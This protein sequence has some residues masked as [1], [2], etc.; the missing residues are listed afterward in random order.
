[1]D[2]DA[3][4]I[5]I[6]LLTITLIDKGNIYAEF[7]QLILQICTVIGKIF[8]YGSSWNSKYN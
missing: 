4:D 5:A 7:F 6:G 2:G 1:M 3:L 8:F